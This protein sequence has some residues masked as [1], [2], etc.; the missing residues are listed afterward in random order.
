MP[1]RPMTGRSSATESSALKLARKELLKERPNTARGV[2]LVRAAFKNGDPGAAYALATWYLH[3][4][5]VPKNLAKA[6]Q[7]LE[8]AANRNIPDALYDLALSYEKGVG[9]KKDPKKAYQLYL[10]AALWGDHQSV[11]EVGRCL[12]YGI[13]VKQDRS[14]AK[15]WLA[16]SK[17]LG[18]FE[19]LR[20]NK[21]H[22]AG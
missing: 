13:G 7:L 9:A 5:Y 10:R 18:V 15:F 17:A 11:F 3:G 16:R 12:F 20:P 21:A 1:K 4:K 19:A 2:K 14:T 6:V 22:K 8:V